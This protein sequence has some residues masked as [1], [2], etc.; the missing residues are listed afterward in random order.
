MNRRH[1]SNA[2]IEIIPAVLSIPT[3]ATIFG[4]VSYNFEIKIMTVNNSCTDRKISLHTV[5]SL[6]SVPTLLHTLC[7][8]I[9]KHWGSLKWIKITLSEIL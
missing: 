2:L 4:R 9:G 7:P 1:M 8:P 3:V 6:T 5:A